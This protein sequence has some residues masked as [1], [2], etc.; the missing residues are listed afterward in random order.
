MA[1]KIDWTVDSVTAPT[2]LVMSGTGMAGVKATF[3]F[4]VEPADAGSRFT[5]A[6]DF[7][8]AMVKGALAKAVEKDGAKQLDRSLDAL[9]A[10]A[11]ADA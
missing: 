10:L 6:G 8:G 2:R 4:T 5:V 7:E 9:D 1:N 3:E 11:L